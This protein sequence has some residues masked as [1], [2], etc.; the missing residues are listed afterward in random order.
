MTGS[1]ERA[2]EE[3]LAELWPSIQRGAMMRAATAG[4]QPR[5]TRFNKPWRSYPGSV[6]SRAESSRSKPACLRTRRRQA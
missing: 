4:G 3:V 5:S 1:G 6:A 2:A